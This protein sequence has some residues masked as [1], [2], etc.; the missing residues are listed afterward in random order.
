M[1]AQ[2]LPPTVENFD[3]ALPARPYPGLRAFHRDEWP[4]FFG[5]ERMTEEVIGRLVRDHL[6]VVHGDSGCG[7]S[8]LVCAGVLPRLEQD[9][10]RS[11]LTW[12]ACVMQPADAPLKGLAAAL[13]TLDSNPH[14]AIEIRRALNR[15]IDAAPVL[16]ELLRRGPDDH[17]CFVVDQFEELF[18][19]AGRYGPEEAVL[20]AEVLEGLLSRKPEGLYALLTMR[21]EFLGHCAR[22]PGLA[23]TV[24]K[25]QYLLPRMT[26]ADLLR[27]IR[28][29]ARLYGGQVSV[30]L[31]ER[32]V[33]DAGGDQ[34]QLPLI[35]H[36]LMVLHAAI[37]RSNAPGETSASGT[38][39][40]G[41]RWHLDVEDYTL[42]V[43]DVLSN[44]ADSL[45]GDL[46]PAERRIIEMVFRSLSELKAEGSAIRRPQTL[47]VLS[48]VAGVNEPTLDALLRPF[49]ADGASFLRPYGDQPLAAK[50]RV[51]VSHEALLRCWTSIADENHGWLFREFQDGLIWKSLL[52]Q[53]T[54]FDKS[55]E[56][57]LSP[58]TAEERETWLA[59]HNA[60]WAERYGGQWDRVT[61]LVQASLEAARRSEEK[62]AKAR[63]WRWAAWALMAALPLVLLG[64]LYFY[65]QAEQERRLRTRLLDEQKKAAESARQKDNLAKILATSSV[66]YSGMQAND[67]DIEKTIAR[68]RGT[69]LRIKDGRLDATSPTTADIAAQKVA[70]ER[71]AQSVGRIVTSG[72][73]Y[74]DWLGTTFMVGPDMVVSVGRNGSHFKKDGSKRIPNPADQLRIDFSEGPT[75]VPAASFPVIELVWSSGE[76]H[77]SISLWRI[78]TTPLKPGPTLPPPLPVAADPTLVSGQSLYLVGYLSRDPRHPAPVLEALFG[79]VF[80]VKRATFGRVIAL[81]KDQL[82]HDCYTTGGA[83]GSPV[84]DPSTGLVVGIQYANG[85][86][87]R[88]AVGSSKIAQA[89]ASAAQR[90]PDE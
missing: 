4:I 48:G 45:L 11:S 88:V 35:Q 30:D 42:H 31:A 54:E 37:V 7:K 82:V 8:S 19:F 1:T 24:N 57:V 56:H 59:G 50:E 16:A 53:A 6:V 27:A 28:E 73:P 76:E 25:G 84:I 86:Q 5:R 2:R 70:I 65:R 81:S 78:A 58:A 85:P 22:L 34:D 71:S 89:L 13:A 66:N 15:G 72:D 20:F 79:N 87:G 21:S 77:T 74:T 41:D 44:H 12:R 55:H 3:I 40:S 83:G 32:L 23:E 75:K 10:A 63:M 33:A 38:R 61:T 52:I 46:S 26:H 17:I 90:L 62:R 39:R 67:Q 69:V 47:T 49:R 64:G 18:S 60:A 51:D 80:D 29:P 36:G 68:Y 43:R 14:R 9:A